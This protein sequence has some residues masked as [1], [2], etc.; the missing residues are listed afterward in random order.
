MFSILRFIALIDVCGNILFKF[1]IKFSIPSSYSVVDKNK[2]GKSFVLMGLT[3]FVAGLAG[4]MVLP[5]SH[6]Y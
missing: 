4:W 6:M 5:W 1:S 3:L 2:Q